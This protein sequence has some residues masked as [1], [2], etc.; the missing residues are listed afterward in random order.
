MKQPQ[1]TKGF[2][3]FC[4]LWKYLCIQLSGTFSFTYDFFEAS[5]FVRC[6][7]VGWVNNDFALKFVCVLF[8]KFFDRVEPN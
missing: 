5:V 2:G 8:K 3:K 7:G 1:C 4:T 6:N